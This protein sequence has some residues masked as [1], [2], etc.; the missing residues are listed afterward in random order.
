MTGGPSII[1]TRRHKVGETLIRGGKDKPCQSIFGYDANSLYLYAICQD[2][3][4]SKYIRCKSA[5]AFRPESHVKLYYAIYDWMNWLSCKT[6]KR[7][8]HKMNHG[9]EFRIG[10]Y[11]VD[12]KSDTNEVYEFLGCY[13]HGCP[14]Q[15]SK[16]DKRESKF[17]STMKRLEFLKQQGFEVITIW[18]C[19]YRQQLRENEEMRAF[20]R[21][22]LPHFY[23]KHPSSVT[24]EEIIE[25]VVNDELFGFVELDIEIPDSWQDV[26]YKPITDLSPYEY[27]KE[28]SSLFLTTEIPF[29]CIGKHMQDHAKAF[30]LSEKPRKLL[31]GG[32]RAKSILIMI[33][34]FKWYVSHGMHVTK[35]HQVIEFSRQAC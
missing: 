28:M 34:L 23:R 12:G 24:R 15:S 16:E 2:M 11:Y 29:S 6:G 27:Y 13:F 19:E 22:G 7:I 26:N 10:P 31:V 33:H 9:Q 14:C 18:Y 4:T 21:N 35:V 8:K 5:N 17:Q 1:F 3:P 32:L 30:N 20:V 25:G